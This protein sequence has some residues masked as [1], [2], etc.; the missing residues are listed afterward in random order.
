MTRSFWIVLGVCLTLGLTACKV[1]TSDPA[2]YVPLVSSAVAGCDYDGVVDYWYFE[3]IVDDG[4]GPNDIRR[5]VAYVYD[6]YDAL[7]ESFELY[8]TNDPWV[9]YSDWDEPA[10]SLYCDYPYYTVEFTVWDSFSDSHTIAVIPA[11]Y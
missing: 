1:R 9:W 2:N 11:T 4:D 8:E 5:V 6:E 10:T 7:I 3:A